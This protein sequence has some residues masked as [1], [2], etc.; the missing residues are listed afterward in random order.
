MRKND[1]DGGKR[2][3]LCFDRV[4]NRQQPIQELI[5]A[6]QQ[7][8]NQ[9]A[10]QSL[11]S[12]NPSHPTDRRNGSWG[13][14]TCLDWVRGSNKVKGTCG[15]V[16]F[17]MFLLKTILGCC[18]TMGGRISAIPA[19][20]QNCGWLSQAKGQ[21]GV[22]LSLPESAIVAQGLPAA[23]LDGLDPN[24]MGRPPSPVPDRVR[25]MPHLSSAHASCRWWAYV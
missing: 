16:L 7:P 3:E 6:N 24:S 11:P 5:F 2:W 8:F 18:G 4:A 1:E 9:Q 22:H 21:W 14:M 25:R 23:A 20:A 13:K 19:P 17:V 15:N 10:V 12:N